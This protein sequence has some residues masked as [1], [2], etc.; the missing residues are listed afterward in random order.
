MK[1]A[2]TVLGVALAAGAWLLTH[3]TP[4]A[5]PPIWHEDGGPRVIGKRGS[6]A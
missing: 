4:P 6:H 5:K 2:L 1:R 3:L